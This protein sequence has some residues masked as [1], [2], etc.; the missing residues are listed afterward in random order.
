[1]R[2]QLPALAVGLA[3]AALAA[4]SV[5]LQGSG[6]AAPGRLADFG[7]WIADNF[8]TIADLAF[9]GAVAVAAIVGI[10]LNRRLVEETSHLRHAET[11][12]FVAVY[13]EYQR[14]RPSMLDVVILNAGR[15]PAYDVRFTVE[16]DIPLWV[17]EADEEDEGSEEIEGPRLSGFGL[18]Q[19][20]LKFIAPSQEIRFFYGPASQVTREPITIRATYF[21]EPLARG[22][23]RLAETYV[24]DATIYDGMSTVGTPP[25]VEIA[26]S[27]TGIRKDIERIRKGSP[28]S[29]LNVTVKRRYALGEPIN[30]RWSRLTRWWKK[31]LGGWRNGNHPWQRRWAWLRRLVEK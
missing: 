13:V 21:D 17:I 29:R 30:R 5:V 14:L 2:S 22:R 6:D 24:I 12:P 31:Q 16:P 28:L 8:A 27:L 11:D 4:G 3:L 9:A 10:R 7:C 25:E 23:N 20:G 26:N 1:M 19:N 15:G 18:F